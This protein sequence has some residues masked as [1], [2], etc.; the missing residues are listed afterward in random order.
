MSFRDVSRG[1]RK[2]NGS[3]DD[4]LKASNFESNGNL[5][6]FFL[7][8]PVPSIIHTQKKT[9]Q[10]VRLTFFLQSKLSFA[11][12]SVLSFNHDV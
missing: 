6:L 11:S 8:R 1:T 10:D 9:Y 4:T 5:V 12:L 2:V 7:A 3:R